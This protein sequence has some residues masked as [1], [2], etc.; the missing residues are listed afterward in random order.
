MQGGGLKNLKILNMSDNQI[1]SI[2]EEIGELK[3]LKS[4]FIHGNRF[5]SFPCSLAS[6]SEL[7]EFSL[8]W[9][10][11]C[12]P[13]RPKLVKKNLNIDGAEVFE[14]LRVLCGL[15]QKYKMNECAIITFL[16]NYSENVFDINNVDN[17]L[18]TPL[19]NAAVKND[20]GVLEGLLIGKADTNILDKDNCT[21]LCLAIREEN[22]Q[23]AS[24]LINSNIDVN[25][26]GGIFGSP[27]H[28]AV[29]KLEIWLVRALVQKGADLNKPD[30]D[31]NTPLHL[32]MNVFSKNPQKCAYI[33]EIL[34]SN[35]AKVNIKNVDNWAPLHIAVRKGQEKGVQTILKLNKN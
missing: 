4:L 26:G 18:R 5:I 19:H 20:C 25:A 23:A 34:V 22:F 13:P 9:F 15:L 3:S 6:L 30:C 24:I 14:S 21:P 16:E 12:K 17:R 1:K 31:G 35:G 7:H 32:V 2:P 29:V 10:M 11:Y 8:E 33:T 28:L 27:M